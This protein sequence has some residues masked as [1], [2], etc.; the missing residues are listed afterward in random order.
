MN[1]DLDFNGFEVQNKTYDCGAHA[2]RHALLA[3]GIP[4]THSSVIRTAETLGAWGSYLRYGNLRNI[5]TSEQKICNALRRYG[6]QPDVFDSHSLERARRFIDGALKRGYPVILSVDNEDHWAT[7][8]GAEGGRYVVAD[9]WDWHKYPNSIKAVSL[10]TWDQLWDQRWYYNCPDCGESIDERLCQ[11]EEWCP[12]CDGHCVN[13]NGGDCAR[14]KGKGWIPCRV[15][16]GHGY[17]HYAICAI[18]SEPSLCEHSGVSRA[19]VFVKPLVRDQALQEYWGYYLSDLLDCQRTMRQ[20]QSGSALSV[21]EELERL[22]EELYET[23]L[24]WLADLPRASILYELSNYVL[25]ARTYNMLIPAD[26]ADR[27]HR[28]FTM[29]FTMTLAEWYIF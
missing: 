6:F 18:P 13:V 14:C 8:I 19:S 22:R 9:S 11:G 26:K 16:R 24:H 23:S 12:S 7:A 10:Y 28:E 15:C 20:V 27:F 29:A 3:V 17:R 21:A 1:T 5:G 4:S 25:V 2:I